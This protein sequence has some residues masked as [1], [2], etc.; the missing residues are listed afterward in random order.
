MAHLILYCS[1][2]YSCMFVFKQVEASKNYFFYPY[3]HSYTITNEISQLGFHTKKCKWQ[4]NDYLWIVWIQSFS[5]IQDLFSFSYM[6]V[7]PAVV[8]ILDCGLTQKTKASAM[9]LSLPLICLIIR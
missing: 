6:V 9:T 7:C 8:A 5:S 2:G 4:Y 1:S 3:S